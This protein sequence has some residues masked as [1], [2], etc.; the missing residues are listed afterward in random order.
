MNDNAQQNMIATAV[1]AI[2]LP[3]QCTMQYSKS[4][5]Q[6]LKLELRFSNAA[7]NNI[8]GY[9]VFADELIMPGEIIEECPIVLLSGPEFANN[10]APQVKSKAENMAAKPAVPTTLQSFCLQWSDQL[11]ALLLGYGGIYN[12]TDVTAQQ[13]AKYFIDHENKLVVFIATKTIRSGE[14]IF[15]N[16]GI[17][18]LDK[19]KFS[20]AASGVLEQTVFSPLAAKKERKRLVRIVLFGVFLIAAY[21][22]VPMHPK[23][24]NLFDLITSTKQQLQ[25]SQQPQTATTAQQPPSKTTTAAAAK[26]QH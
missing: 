24:Q 3:E 12:H 2:P 15:V 9:G 22:F 4:R 11:Y 13:N 21:A 5:L 25:S 6:H 26:K 7:I 1:T 16:C 14:E 23:F 18:W 8:Y 17:E 20:S 10:T 19:R